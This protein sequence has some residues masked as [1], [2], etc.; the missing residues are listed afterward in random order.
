M[1]TAD[2][3]SGFD[4]PHAMADADVRYR[5]R[6]LKALRQPRQDNRPNRIARG[7]RDDCMN[8]EKSGQGDG[9]IKN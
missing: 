7:D 8:G 5:Y 4:D 1:I 6:D 3:E 2:R 9:G